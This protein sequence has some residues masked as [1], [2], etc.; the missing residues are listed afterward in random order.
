MDEE[1]AKVFDLAGSHSSFAGVA[2]HHYEAWYAKENGL[3]WLAKVMRRSNGQHEK[4]GQ[5]KASF[6]LMETCL[7]ICHSLFAELNLAISFCGFRLS[8][9]DWAAD[10]PVLNALEK[11]NKSG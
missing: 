9:T 8:G 7:F 5:Q 1:I 4:A 10:Q 11:E 3:P 2:V 6:R